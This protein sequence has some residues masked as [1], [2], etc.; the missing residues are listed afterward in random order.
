MHGVR[1]IFTFR[2]L[3]LRY[4]AACH[5][6]VLSR[7]LSA[8]VDPIYNCTANENARQRLISRFDWDIHS[9]FHIG[10]PI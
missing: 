6:D 2:C 9:E 10:L 1:R 3:G 7:R 5:A 8:P 4:Y